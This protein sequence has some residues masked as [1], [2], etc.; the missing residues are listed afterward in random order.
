MNKMINLIRNENMKLAHSISTWIMMGLLVII[1]VIMGLISKF[2]DNT[3]PKNDWKENIITRNQSINESLANIDNIEM[4]KMEKDSLKDEVQ[5]N[6]Y[7]LKNDIQ[8][9]QWNSLW[10]FVEGIASMLISLIAL[11]AIVM[12]G[13]IV[14]NE[15][16]GGTIKLLLIRPS[17]RWKILVSKYISV[18]TYTFFMVLILLVVS[19]LIGGILFSFKGASAPFL[20]N[21]NGQI[22]EVNMIV[23]IIQLC[24]LKCISLVMM[25]TL[26]FMIS[27]VFR[28]S[29]MAIGIGVFLL[30]VGNGITMIL[31]RFNWSKYILFSN[32]DLTQYSTGKPL[33]EGMTIE[34]SIIVLIV[35]FVIFNV[36]SY[37]GFTKRD[38]VA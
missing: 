22:N 2:G 9:I 12:G 26:A 37:I 27:T 31:S 33:V 25:V 35:Y 14:A 24:G 13:G 7:R 10:G 15:F 20:T 17:K 16:S 34:F 3:P 18:I 29:A 32:T 8:P 23:H 28:N 11:F 4:S 6:E 19:F 36:I 1:I 38:I 5:T 21:S 30:T